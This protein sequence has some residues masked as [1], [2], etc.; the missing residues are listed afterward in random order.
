MIS[1]IIPVWL[2]TALWLLGNSPAAAQSHASSTLVEATDLAADARLA[3]ARGVPLVVL[4]SR[5]DCSWCE[6]VRREHLGPLSRDPAAPALVRE[7]HMDRATPLVDFAGRR[8]TSADFSKQMQARF[9]PTV[10]FHGGKGGQLVEA[11]VGF[12]LADFYAAYLERA[13]EESQARLKQP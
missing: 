8:T 3:A 2:G 10:M 12:R 4:Y 6:K 9:A 11:I 1:R 13:L 7:L 5:D